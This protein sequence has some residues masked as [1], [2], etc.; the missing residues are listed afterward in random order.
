L[1]WW[2]CLA[3]GWLWRP[4]CLQ[5]DDAQPL[6]ALTPVQLEPSSECSA[7]PAPELRHALRIELG[8]RLS[9]APDRTALQVRL[10]CTQDAVQ[11]H[12]TSPRG[13][14]RSELLALAGASPD[15][16]PRIVALRIAELV[17]SVDAEAARVEVASTSVAAMPVTTAREAPPPRATS[18]WRLG[19]F[20]QLLSFQRDGRWLAGAGLRVGY[21]WRVLSLALDAA[22]A[23]RSF[24]SRLGEARATL[25]HLAPQL[26]ASLNVHRLSFRFGVG[27]ALGFAQLR[28]SAR[29]SAAT[30]AGAAE[31]TGVWAAPFAALELAYAASAR[32][33]LRT[34]AS[35][36][37]VHARVIGEVERARDI[38][39]AGLLTQ[40]QLGL[41]LAL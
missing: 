12:V 5:A 9:D 35:L 4:D 8:A 26:A 24:S 36:G 17:R 15:L 30:P 18:H 29:S 11:L 16:R 14:T 13:T 25:G 27:Y 31:R 2:T 6:P 7:A 21:D 38:Q 39:V 32:V 10:T 37:W 20:A 41:A 33:Q 23:S 40:F 19:A 22:L 34:Q 1:C 28:G 3:L